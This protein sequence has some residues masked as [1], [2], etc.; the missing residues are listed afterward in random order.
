MY[1]H[2][3]VLASFKERLLKQE[4]AWTLA[5]AQLG[6]YLKVKDVGMICF[7]DLPE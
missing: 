1:L 6:E 3:N 2:R 7:V 5:N 4:K